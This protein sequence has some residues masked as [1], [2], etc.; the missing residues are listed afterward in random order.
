MRSATLTIRGSILAF[1]L[2]LVFAT[3]CSS[4]EDEKPAP[5]D[6]KTANC[7]SGGSGGT[8]GTG[9]TP[10]A[11]GEP[12]PIECSG[13]TCE[14]LDILFGDIPS[15]APCC[16]DDQGCGL[17]SSF[18]SA[19]GV[20]FSESCQARDQPGELDAECPESPPLMRPE[21]PVA[22]KFKGCCRADSSTCG[23]M[24]DTLAGLQPIGLGCID[25]TPFLEG[26][27]AEPCTPAGGAGASN[28]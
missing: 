23:Y 28:R 24:L 25:S 22:V 19:F 5:C 6:P 9:G 10:G 16:T 3:S 14:P 8:G 1:S 7:G 17:D 27:T 15:I 4:D 26:G 12:E 2:G 21:L 20:M 18:L 13:N 11:G